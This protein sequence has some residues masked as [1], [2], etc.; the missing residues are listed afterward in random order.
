MKKVYKFILF[1]V[2]L[3]IILFNIL[4]Y[5]AACFYAMPAVDDFGNSLGLGDNI[6][7]IGYLFTAIKRATGVYMTWQGTYFSDFLM[8]YLAV[9]ARFGIWG[10]RVF[11]ILNLL[12]F[13]GSL[14]V[15]LREVFNFFFK[16]FDNGLILFIYA[17]L[18]FCCVNVII[19]TETFFWFTAACV[20]TI[21]LSFA[22]LAFYNLLRFL[23]T[24]NRKYMMGAGILGFLANGGVLQIPAFVCFFFLSILVWSY[25][26]RHEQ[27]RKIFILFLIV[28]AGALLNALAPG[29]FIRAETA[30]GNTFHIMQAVI[31]S[32]E[33]LLLEIKALLTDTYAPF[34]MVVLFCVSVIFIP[35]FKQKWYAIVVVAILF[36]GGICISNFP[37]ALV[38]AGVDFQSRNRF[39]LDIL[40]LF[41]MVI[42][43][44]MLANLLKCSGIK[45]N[46]AIV[47][48]IGVLVLTVS[49]IKFTAWEEIFEIPSV[50]CGKQVVNGSLQE[51]SQQWIEAL[52]VIEN[53]Q[54][55]VVE[56]SM[57]KIVEQTVLIGPDFSTDPEYWVNIYVAEYYDKEKIYIKTIQ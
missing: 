26:F 29:N 51:W 33:Y 2:A 22:F 37:V 34:V 18:V 42:G 19:P 20:Y 6:G 40:I 54:E 13:M 44:V 24:N 31:D 43:T 23:Q 15:L 48:I 16:T 53:S 10:I 5:L 1:S 12:F 50:Q 52:N 8:Y 45:I 30:T 7:E 57:K 39:I 55:N 47:V 21:P 41:G 17:F 28:F 14:W 46:N 11:C 56:V 9:F 4:P 38:Y 27:K 36:L 32:G 3:A 49:L 35:K 25:I